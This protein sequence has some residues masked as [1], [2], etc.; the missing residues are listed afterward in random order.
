MNLKKRGKASK[1]WGLHS[2]TKN[3]WIPGTDL[4]SIGCAGAAKLI[5][6]EKS[7][8]RAY[9]GL[10]GVYKYLQGLYGLGVSVQGYGTGQGFWAANPCK[11]ANG[12][13]MNRTWHSPK[14]LNPK[15][16]QS[17]RMAKGQITLEAKNSSKNT[18]CEKSSIPCKTSPEPMPPTILQE[19]GSSSSPKPVLQRNTL[20]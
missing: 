9:E 18:G 12:N 19:S 8:K 14:L 20:S 7:L 11:E 2:A 4:N 15:P 13:T 16:T 6:P 5:R 17:L 1:A 3:R 10:F